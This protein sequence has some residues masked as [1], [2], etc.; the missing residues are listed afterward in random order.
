MGR[1]KEWLVLGKAYVQVAGIKANWF[2]PLEGHLVF[3]PFPKQYMYNKIHNTSPQF[4]S[5]L[6]TQV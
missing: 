3:G 4:F 5:K 6:P 1:N 2:F